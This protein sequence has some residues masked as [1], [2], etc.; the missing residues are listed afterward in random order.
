[1][2]TV[3]FFLFI[4]LAVVFGLTTSAI[5]SAKISRDLIDSKKSYFLAEAGIE[6]AVHRIKT[7]KQ[8]SVEE[9]INLDGQEA[10]I[11][12]TD[13]NDDKEIISI[14]DF[15]GLIRKIKTKLSIS[16]GVEF[17]YGAHVG[18]GGIEMGQNSRIEGTGGEV[19]NIYSNGPIVGNN[20]AVITGS[21]TVASGISED[22]QARSLVC[23]QDQIVGQFNP[24]ID[25]AQSFQPSESKPLSKISLYIKKVDNPGDRDIRIT[26]DFGGSPDQNYIAKAKLLS[27]LVGN[28]YAWIDITFSSPP[29][30][31][32][33]TTYWIVLDAKKDA[34]KYWV[35]CKDNNQ[36]YGNGVAKYSEDWDDDPWIQITG[37][38]T[39]KTYLGTGVS[40]ID[41]MTI[42]GDARANSIT[43]SQICGDAYYQT[44]DVDSLNF[45]NNP[46]NPTCPDPLTP[47]AA[48]DDQ[49]APS[50]ENMPISDGNIQ[51][52]ENGAEAGGIIDGNCGDNGVPECDIPDDDILLLGPKK[53]NGNLILT[54]KQT[55]V[56]K[57]GPLYFTGYIDIDS[58]HGAT[59]KCDSSFGSKGCIIITDSW[60]HIENNAVFQ[61]SGEKGSYIIFLST[62]VGCTGGEQKPQCTHH[63]GAIDIHNNA[64]GAIFYSTG[65]LA[66][67]HNGV[68]I[69]EITAYKLEL[70]NTAVVA[71][72]QGLINSQFSSGPSGSWRI[73][74]WSEVD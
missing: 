3:I 18:E 41:E 46:S 61:G 69:T 74:D 5:S 4:S 7:G 14:S 26:T 36:G 9:T 66:H 29:N 6:D 62:L 54:K 49:P 57:D 31:V 27:S 32:S 58:S 51:D 11:N 33:G 43:N 67:L 2:T 13:I 42:W 24:E 70:G 25:F 45:L 40:F 48:F 55:L 8:I 73:N 20:G 71:Y 72:E 22:N 53:I 35:W 30:L 44:I 47:G 59:I 37:D 1:M 12:L 56:V 39:F 21:A 10:V 15:S 17:F 50:I 68:N 65:S 28:D 52:W 34:N 63:N 16:I 64:T 23:D 19:G 60:I 38:M